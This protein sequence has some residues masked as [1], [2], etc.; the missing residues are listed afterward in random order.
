MA[1]FIGYTRVSTSAQAE[2]Q[3]LDVQR[4][5]IRHWA[6][7]NDHKILY[8]C[9]DIGK[10]GTVGPLEGRQQLATAINILKENQATGLVVFRLDR[11]ARDLALQ[12]TLLRELK[13]LGAELHS[14]SPAED[15][16]IQGDDNLD[17]ARK[18]TRQILGAVAEYERHMIG[19]RMRAG[20]A[21]KAAK[22]GY[23]GGGPPYGW[24]AIG[25]ELVPRWDQQ[26]VLRGIFGLRK[27]GWSPRRIAAYLNA[28]H[29]PGPRSDVWGFKTIYRLLD[30]NRPVDMPRETV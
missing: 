30:G 3:G 6:E 26:E 23:T 4:A 12:E 2:G 20:K 15:D 13:G 28:Q 19:L 14:T 24:S 29:I 9:E 18:L 1:D 25:G 27:N 21:A 7:Q 5:G 17:P 8:W 11:L 22:G 16:M 10:S